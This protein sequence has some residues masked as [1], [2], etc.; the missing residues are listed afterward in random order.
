MELKLNVHCNRELN[1]ELRVLTNISPRR[2]N[3]SM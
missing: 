1:L 2:K 3:V